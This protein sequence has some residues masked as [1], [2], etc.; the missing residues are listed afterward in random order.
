MPRIPVVT[1]PDD[2]RVAKIYDEIK[3]RFGAVPNVLGTFANHPGIFTGIWTMI[4]ALFVET[5]LDP[6]LREL[7]YLRT[8]MLN[9]CHY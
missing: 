1:G 6:K 4:S 2:P 8:S 7:A 3:Q 5:V 9:E